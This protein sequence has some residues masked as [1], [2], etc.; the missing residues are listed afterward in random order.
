MKT[1]ANHLVSL[2]DRNKDGS[3]GTQGNRKVML[4]QIAQQ[5]NQ[6]GYKKMRSSSLKPKHVVALVALWKTEVSPQTKK[7][8][9]IGTIKN[10]MCAMRWWAEKIGKQN[11]IPRTNE[12]LGIANR[13]LVSKEN[14]AFNLD[15]KKVETL[16]RHIRLSLRLQEQFGFRREEAAKIIPGDAIRKDQIVLKPSWTKGGRKRSVPIVTDE[17]RKLVRDLER[18]VATNGK[19]S[20]IPPSINY[21]RYLSHREHHITSIGIRATHGLRHHYAQQRYLALT[22]GLL[23]RKLGGPLRREMTDEEK[24]DRHCCTIDDLK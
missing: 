13:V 1:L 10:R 21:E 15:Y 22:N 23:P 19:A 2:C 4:K 18:Y 7:P 5:L 9:S 6:L 17:Q 14:K 8:I 12:E 24:K 3:F 11:V 20:L 16:P